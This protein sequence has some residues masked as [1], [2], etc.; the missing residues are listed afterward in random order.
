MPN[1]SS[2]ASDGVIRFD[3]SHGNCKLND[4]QANTLKPKPRPNQGSQTGIYKVDSIKVEYLF[5]NDLVLTFT[6]CKDIAESLN[7]T[8]SDPVASSLASDVEYRINQVIEVCFNITNLLW[9]I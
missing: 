8:L 1:G 6:L 7:I 5:Q 9:F 3:A 4:M 2:W